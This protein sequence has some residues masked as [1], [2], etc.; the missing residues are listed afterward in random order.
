M[1][2]DISEVRFLSDSPKDGPAFLRHLKAYRI[3]HPNLQVRA[4]LPGQIHDRYL[5]TAQNMWSIGHSLNAIGSKQTIVAKVGE[6]V[7]KEM[8]KSF[9]SM[10]ATA[11]VLA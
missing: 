7:R 9:D 2:P 8:E 6:D 10:W 5:I 3:E 4:I 11:T 1:I